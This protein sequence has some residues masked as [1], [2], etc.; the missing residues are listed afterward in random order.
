MIDSLF[1][2]T[3]AA[4]S[5]AI[6]YYYFTNATGQLIRWT[7][8]IV[9]HIAVSLKSSDAERNYQYYPRGIMPHNYTPTIFDIPSKARCLH[10]FRIGIKIKCSSDGEARLNHSLRSASVLCHERFTWPTQRFARLC[11]P[12]ELK[13][14]FVS[15]YGNVLRRY[16][17]QCVRQVNIM[18]SFVRLQDSSE[19]L[20]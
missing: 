20:S 3:P 1:H 8:L 16:L 15:Q 13:P 18:N 4:R 14:N 9:R 6:C 2:P 10:L 7:E 12:F 19:G 17:G 5:T 11:Y